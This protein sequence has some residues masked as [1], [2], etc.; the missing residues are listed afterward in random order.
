M[1]KFFS[2]LFTLLY[3]LGCN[4]AAKTYYIGFLSALFP[5]YICALILAVS[6]IFAALIWV[7]L[8]LRIKLKTVRMGKLKIKGIWLLCAI[9]VPA[10]QFFAVIPFHGKWYIGKISVIPYL[11]SISVSLLAYALIDE[12]TFRSLILERTENVFGKFAALLI[13]SIVY[14]GLYC[15]SY[16]GE[17]VLN[18]LYSFTLPFL[19][20][21]LLALVT[22]QSEGISNAIIIHM[23]HSVANDLIYVGPS[24][25]NSAL[26]NFVT[27]MNSWILLGIRSIATIIF[28]VIALLLLRK[29]KKEE[30]LYW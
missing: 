1:K 18:I 17:P 20:S 4:F 24:K 25:N 26:F 5:S 29:K 21:V 6:F 12:I 10:I 2:F 9:L 30:V 7:R 22:Y 19:I 28:I 27:D 11:A 8:I 3:A 15:I 16:I 23:V 13:T 14:A